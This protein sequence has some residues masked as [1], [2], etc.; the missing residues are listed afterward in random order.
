MPVLSKTVEVD[1]NADAIMAIV[2]DFERY[3]DWSEGAKGCW[4]LAR[5]DDG[6]P[7]QIRLDAA[8]Q[9]FEG[10]FIQAIYYPGPNQIQTV[11]Q[12]GELFKK[13]EQLFSVVEMGAASLLTVDIDVEPSMPVPAPMVKMMLNNVLDHLADNLKK[14]AEQL[15]AS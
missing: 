9:G 7:S 14:R 3:P 15:A 1:A 5:Y 8:Y 12:Q 4:V 10:T 2:A 13:Q 6:R 11:L